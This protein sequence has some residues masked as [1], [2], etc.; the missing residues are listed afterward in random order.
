MDPRPFWDAADAPDR[1]GISEIKHITGLYAMWDALIARHPGLLIDN[2]SS[3]GRRIDLE[4][5]SR[6]MP[7]WR[8]DLQCWP[9]FNATI[10]QTQTRRAKTRGRR[11]NSTDPILAR[12][13]L[14]RCV[15]LPAPTAR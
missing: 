14:S 11:G 9:N 12:G 3:G 1:V 4:T 2:C 13:P 8:S 7:L 10:M 15:A 5:I 6:S